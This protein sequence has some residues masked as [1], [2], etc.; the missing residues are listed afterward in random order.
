M[1]R[2]D[3][4]TDD[5]EMVPEL[6]G[7]DTVY[8]SV[9]LAISEAVYV[10]LEKEKEAAQIAARAEQVHCPDWLGAR[11]FP[12]GGS[13]GAP[14]LIETDDFTLKV[15]SRTMKN[16]PGLYVELRSHFLHTH[17]EGPAGACEEA[18]C[19]AREQLYYDQ[20]ASVVAGQLSFDAAK[21]SRVDLHCDWQG[22]YA[23]ALEYISDDLRCFIR[24]G[25]VKWSL[26]GEGHTFTGYTFGHGDVRA[27]L[28]NKSLEVSQRHDDS[29]FTLL[30]A[31]NG[32]RFNPER[33]V[34]RLEYQLRREGA[35]G[36]KL[37]AEPDS[38]DDDV[39][40]EAELA[41]EDLQHL[42][43]LPRFFARQQE[44]WRYL[45]GHWLRLAV[46]SHEAN[47]SRWPTHPDWQRLQDEYAPLALAGMQTPLDEVDRRV[48]RGARYSGKS[49]LLRR[50]SL[51][52]VNSLEVE[53]ASPTAAALARLR[54]EAERIAAKE[55]ERAEARR[56]RYLA[57]Y[58]TVPRWVER[59]MGA[60]LERAEQV[61][62]R[63]Q[64]LLG[65]FAAQ[66]VLP[67][68]LK[69]A[70]NVADLLVQHLDDLEAEAEEKGGIGQVLRQHFAKVYKVDAPASLF[71]PAR[72]S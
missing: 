58:G 65:I 18:L 29:Y 52:V 70:H 68:E 38:A 41:A 45:T 48:V 37:Y 34:W 3:P 12:N 1:S 2:S 17:P 61:R 31:R 42:G 50:M 26:F 28:Y 40:I 51:G 13:G 6:A 19:W 57:K 30:A 4:D 10:K 20:D 15:S 56:A 39:A 66:G 55:A 14:F 43:T 11:V 27:R 62:H 36:F 67:L 47:R 33:D 46:E 21:L 54:D 63:V 23:P 7:A 5:H 8:F 32:E 44:V 71:A 25:K 24:P 60:R 9:D 64:M 69:P 22:G 16:R 49:R 35:K 72:A 53:D 59:G